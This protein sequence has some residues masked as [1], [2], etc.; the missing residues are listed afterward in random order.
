MK[1][2]T[3][4]PAVQMVGL[5]QEHVWTSVLGGRRSS[6][7]LGVVDPDPQ[8][9]GSNF[10]NSTR[11]WRFALKKGGAVASC[12]ANSSE[13]AESASNFRKTISDRGKPT[14]IPLGV[15]SYCF[16]TLR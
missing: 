2:G 1:A 14:K 9:C 15:S 13:G 16:C 4:R 3:K 5:G 7:W 12:S 11:S 6:R 8:Y 10:S